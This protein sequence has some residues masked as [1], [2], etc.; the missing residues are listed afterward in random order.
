M[1]VM[2]TNQ[3]IA[4]LLIKENYLYQRKYE[5]LC[6]IEWD[7]EENNYEN[8]PHKRKML[9]IRLNMPFYFQGTSDIVATEFYLIDYSQ[10]VA[11]TVKWKGADSAGQR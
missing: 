8:G 5:M 1:A 10:E 4:N 2:S 9:E 6:D 7:D 3:K 11:V